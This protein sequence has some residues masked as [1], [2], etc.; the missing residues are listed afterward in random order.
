METID[1]INVGNQFGPVHSFSGTQTSDFELTAEFV[2]LV[3]VVRVG[4]VL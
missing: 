3:C 1:L 4:D 2:L